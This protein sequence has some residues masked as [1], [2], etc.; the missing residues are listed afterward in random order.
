MPGGREVLGE[1]VRN[2]LAERITILGTDQAS[3]IDG[4]VRNAA[5]RNLAFE[6]RDAGMEAAFSTGVTG[7]LTVAQPAKLMAVTKRE[8]LRKLL[9]LSP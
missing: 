3:S 4:F 7:S 1:H 6:R 9:I 5:E 8:I 2:L